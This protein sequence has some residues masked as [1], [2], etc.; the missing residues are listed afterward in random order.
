MKLY[1]IH[2]GTDEVGL[3]SYFL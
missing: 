3:W 2:K 1:N